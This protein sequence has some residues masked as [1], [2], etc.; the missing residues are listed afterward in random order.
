MDQLVSYLKQYNE[1]C[2][3]QFKGQVIEAITI[4]SSAI[5]K[6]KFLPHA[7]KVVQAILEIQLTQL[8]Q[9]DPQKSY[10]LSAWQRICLLLKQDFTKY[11]SAVLPSIFKMA[12]LNPEMSI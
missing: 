12:T 4:L 1:P 6:E 8:E 7:D 10:L 11:L 9:K 3:K 5:G 2:F